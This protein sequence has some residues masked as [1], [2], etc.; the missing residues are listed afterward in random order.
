MLQVIRLLKG[1]LTIKVMGSSPERFM[2]LCS[3]H[4]IFLWDIKKCG[5]YYLMKIL[6]SDFYGIK[7]FT[8]KTGTKVVVT[9]RFGL[10]FLSVKMKKR[11]IFLT[12]IAGS[13]IFW[14][15]MSLFIWTIELDGNYYITQDVF[16]DFLE[17][18]GVHHGTKKK[19]LD[20]EELEKQIRNHFTIVT[21]TSARVEGSRL[22]I[23]IKENEL[24]EEPQ[25][26]EKIPSGMD[27]VATTDG[28]VVS[29]VTRTGVPMVKEGQEVKKGDILVQGA[30]PIMSEDGLVRKYEFCKADADVYLAC[31]KRMREELPLFY[32]YKDYTGRQRKRNFIEFGEKKVN[33]GFFTKKYTEYD[34]IEEKS[35]WELFG[36]L[37]LPVYTGK[38]I[39][40]EYQGRIMNYTR[41][42]VKEIFQDK[43]L[44]IM[45]TLEEKGVQIIEKNV[46][47]KKGEKKWILEIRFMV[48]EQDGIE[49]ETSVLQM[50]QTSQPEILEQ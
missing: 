10:P 11:I 29:I 22:I 6:L 1:F 14:L 47:I 40:R 27:L 36:S 45:Q 20:I 43:I 38:E 50:E 33:I 16:M 39:R 48:V 19:Q 23:Q 17:E 18:N 21:W 32:L 3:N 26:K 15:W 34:V 28:K 49:K 9:E 12:G 41:E 5:D 24:G 44:K 37:T 8:R 7:S 46:T 30:V 13:F 4:H 25:E 35:Q 31:E 42:Q 2:N